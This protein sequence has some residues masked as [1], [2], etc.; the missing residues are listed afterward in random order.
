MESKTAAINILIIALLFIASNLIEFT[1]YD[2]PSI[3][4]LAPQ[5]TSSHHSEVSENISTSQTSVQSNEPPIVKIAKP[6]DGEIIESFYLP[7]YVPISVEIGDNKDIDKLEFYVDDELRDTRYFSSSTKVYLEGGAHTIKVIVYDKEGLKNQDTVTIY[8]KKISSSSTSTSKSNEPP[9]VR[10]IEP[11]NGE[12]IRV[13]KLP[14][15]LT[16]KVEANDDKSVDKIEF[17]VDNEL[18]ETR[19]FLR[20]A[21]VYLEEGFH[22]I[23]AVAYDDDGLTDEDIVSVRVEKIPEF[24]SSS[25]ITP[26]D[27]IGSTS[28]KFEE[29]REKPKTSIKE[30]ASTSTTTTETAIEPTPKELEEDRE[31]PKI[32]PIQFTLEYGIKYKVKVLEVIDGDTIDV[33]LPNGSVERVRMLGIDTPEKDPEDNE[34]YEF[35]SISDLDY[36]AEWGEKAAQF[37]ESKLEGRYVYIEFDKI[38]GMR[39]YY[40]RLLAYVYLDGTD[41]TAELVKEGYARVYVEGEFE[42]EDYYIEL[43]NEA[44]EEGKGIWSI[45]KATSTSDTTSTI[46]VEI[47]Y[48]HYDAEGNDNYNL[49]DEYVVI[50]NVGDVSVDLKGWVLKDEA[51]HTF[52][53]PSIILEPGE[54]VIVYSGSGVNSNK[55]LYWGSSRAIWNNNGDTAFLYDTDGNLIDSYSW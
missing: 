49:N 21:T 9:E 31:E 11:K 10:I 54:T 50:K 47:V 5:P 15:S 20:S 40:G 37:T 39:G 8:V 46:S 28:K 36:L 12:V 4:A 29:K 14:A 32:S 53:F 38:A 23:R 22:T 48:V 30:P 42:K 18:E 43:E 44:K 26:K 35:D 25:T 51:E 27:T 2:F 41:F 55:E 1:K 3:K 45:L 13:Q 16:I 6:K 7:A 52:T 33:L 24:T 17:Y 19:Y 34:P